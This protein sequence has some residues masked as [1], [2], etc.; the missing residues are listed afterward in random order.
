MKKRMILILPL[1]MSMAAVSFGSGSNVEETLAARGLLLTLALVFAGGVAVSLTP[2]LYPMIPITLSIIGARSAGQ[3][4]V[5][6]FLRSL[7]FVLGIAVVYTALGFFVARTGGTVGFLFQNKWFVLGVALLF[8]AMGLAMMDYFTIQM[9]AS[10]SGR[11]QSGANRGGFVGAF[12]LGLVTGVVASPCGSPVL[13]GVLGIAAQS[14]RAGV[15]VSLLFAY[16]MGIGL[17]FLLLGTFPAFLG[18][19][20]RSGVWMEDVKKLLGLVMLGV[21]AYYV[22][23]IMPETTYWVMV[24]LLSVA[25]GVLLLERSGS[26]RAFPKLLVAWRVA[27]VL[28]LAMG[29]YAGFWRVPAASG[30][31][32][33]QMAEAA[34]PAGDGTTTTQALDGGAPAVPAKLA[35][36]TSEEEGIARVKATGK[37]MM[38][39]FTAAWCAACK[40]LE[41]DT[42]SHPDVRAALADFVLVKID[43]T[44]ETPEGAELQKKYKSMSLPT[45]AFVTPDGKILD[46]L[47][48]YA[49]ESPAKFLE[50]LAKV[51]Q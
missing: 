51:R 41:R 48:L 49:F 13:V 30:A 8:V 32:A 24:A 16:A 23:T 43:L 33:V 29:A 4:P 22:N 44:E 5:L 12:L 46:N 37:P 1:V 19:M 27:A 20:P 17:L 42:F 45:V 18:R 15:G 3:K 10:I 50:R 35:W 9:P 7:V 40:Q 14:G 2:C 39:D 21:A 26:R 38:V 34:M 47:T 11:L 25:A 36:L 28:L 6:G 31:Q